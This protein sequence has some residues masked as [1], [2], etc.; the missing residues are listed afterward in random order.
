MTGFCCLPACLAPACLNTTPRHPC[1]S[2]PHCLPAD[3][4]DWNI[5]RKGWE[6]HVLG[7]APHYFKD[8][9]TAVKTLRVS[10][11]LIVLRDLGFLAPCLAPGLNPA[12]PRPALCRPAPQ[13]DEGDKPVSDQW[14]DPFVIVGED[15]NPVGTIQDGEANVAGW[16]CRVSHIQKAWRRAITRWAQSRTMHGWPPGPCSM[17]QPLDPA[18]PPN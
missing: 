12:P 8:A 16:G 5:V 3:E 18:P 17:P 1:L 11:V 2:Y 7:E 9:T 10:V 6:A 13:N 14:L 15:N 4:A